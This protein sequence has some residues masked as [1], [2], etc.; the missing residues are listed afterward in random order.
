LAYTE[1]QLS[2]DFNFGK[3]SKTILEVDNIAMLEACGLEKPKE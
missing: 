2:E 3:L 1:S